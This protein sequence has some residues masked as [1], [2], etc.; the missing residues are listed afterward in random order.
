MIASVKPGKPA[1]RLVVQ[2]DMFDGAEKHVVTPG[3]ADIRY[4]ALESYRCIVQDGRTCP[5]FPP[6]TDCEFFVRCAS[7]ACKRIG[8][9][10]LELAKNV[11]TYHA[12]LQKRL[13]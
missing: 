8:N 10:A 11:N 6:D 5:T 13:M 9:R 7:A 3:G 12:V 2:A 4:A 1:I